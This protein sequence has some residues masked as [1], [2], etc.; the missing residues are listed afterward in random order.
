MSKL[1]IKWKKSAIGR[2]D[3][4]ARTIRALGLHKLNGTVVH[5][6]TPQIRGMIRHVGHLVELSS[7]ET[8]G[9]KE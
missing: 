3:I 9:D 7:D 6:D 4:Q 2:P 5:E 8:G 1:V